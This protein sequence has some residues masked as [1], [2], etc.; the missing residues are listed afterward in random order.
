MPTTYAQFAS[1]LG[2]KAGAERIAWTHSNA[3]LIVAWCVAEG[4][5]ASCNPLDDTQVMPGSWPLKGNSANV[6]NY[7]TLDE[8]M[9]AY[10]RTL[11]GPDYGYPA[12]A[13]QLKTGAC[14]C[15]TW[16][17]VQKFGN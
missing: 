4:S 13:E 3:V 8:A 10:L 7:T 16:R 1:Q 9:E 11:E 15:T 5:P 2:I 6:Q 12:I 17:R 14:A